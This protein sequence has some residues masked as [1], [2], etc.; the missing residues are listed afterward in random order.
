MKALA[1]ALTYALTY[2]SSVPRNYDGDADD[3][4]KALECITAT[5]RE[6]TTE[7]RNAIRA[8]C[9]AAIASMTL[10]NHTLVQGYRDCIENFCEA[11][12]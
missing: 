5:L 2:L 8:A 3:D 9:E 4:C 6:A 7:E 10:P 12:D 1:E 11:A